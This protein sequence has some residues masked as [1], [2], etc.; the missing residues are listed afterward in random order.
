MSQKNKVYGIASA[1]KCYANKYIALFTADNKFK[2]SDT[3]RCH[4]FYLDNTMYLRWYHQT[5]KL[6]KEKKPLKNPLTSP[7]ND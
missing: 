6:I 4:L 1:S 3:Y 7:G 2:C 5:S